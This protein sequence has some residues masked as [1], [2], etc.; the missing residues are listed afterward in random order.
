MTSPGFGTDQLRQLD[1]GSASTVCAPCG[2]ESRTSGPASGTDFAS[3]LAEHSGLHAGVGGDEDD[4]YDEDDDETEDGLYGLS[5]VR[6][7]EARDDSDLGRGVVPS[8]SEVRDGV[9]PHPAATVPPI[10]GGFDDLIGL[11]NDHL[12]NLTGQASAA[13]GGSGELLNLSQFEPELV[14]QAASSQAATVSVLSVRIERPDEGA[15]RRHEADG[16]EMRVEVT[17]RQRCGMCA[18]DIGPELPACPFCDLACRG[19]EEGEEEEGDVEEGAGVAA[20]WEDES[21][22][23]GGAE[24]IERSR[25]KEKTGTVKK[26]KKKKKPADDRKDARSGTAE[27]EKRGITKKS[28]STTKKEDAVDEDTPDERKATAMAPSSPGP[29]RVVVATRGPEDGTT[30]GT[31]DGPL[32]RRSRSELVRGLIGKYLAKNRLEDE[33]RRE[34]AGEKDE[35]GVEGSAETTEKVARDDKKE[36]KRKDLYDDLVECRVSRETADRLRSACGA[37]GRSDD[38]NAAVRDGGGSADRESSANEA[39]GVAEAVAEVEISG[40]D[41]GSGRGGVDPPVRGERNVIETASPDRRRPIAGRD[42]G[43]DPPDAREPVGSAAMASV[44]GSVRHSVP[45]RP[46]DGLDD[47]DEDDVRSRLTEIQRMYSSSRGGSAAASSCGASSAASSYAPSS[48][49]SRVSDELSRRRKGKA[50]G[51]SGPPSRGLAT[52]SEC[53]P[54]RRPA[55]GRLWGTAEERRRRY[56]ESL[57]AWREGRGA[58]GGVAMPGAVRAE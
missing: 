28:K 18:M 10:E 38:D 36:K 39:E 40:E 11:A 1:D 49:S 8:P 31:K 5:S 42:Q 15:K 52:I 6:E 32:P 19:D 51:G 17:L 3:R 43:R 21:E 13:G 2:T 12:L 14:L 46:E 50:H 26:P 20:S 57:R 25:L 24:T 45:D 53:A 30:D 4:K 56:K 23:L 55:P 48:V 34:L 29:P 7:D 47:M 54:P 27:K 58:V 16:D 33:R 37:L 41:R 22:S 35:E 44:G 9:C